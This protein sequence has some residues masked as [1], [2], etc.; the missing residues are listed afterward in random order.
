MT[1][2]LAAAG[3]DFPITGYHAKRGGKVLCKFICDGCKE[4]DHASCR[5]ETWCDCQH[6]TKG[7][8]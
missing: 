7:E 2:H 6:R 8:K 1:E 3:C 4:N 5:G